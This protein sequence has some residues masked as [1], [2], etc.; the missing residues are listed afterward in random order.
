[1]SNHVGKGDNLP[2]TSL[3]G[4]VDGDKI[5]KGMKLVPTLVHGDITKVHS[6][7]GG[8]AGSGSY[9]HT[10]IAYSGDAVWDNLI[11]VDINKIPI[12]KKKTVHKKSS[13]VAGYRE[14]STTQIEYIYSGTSQKVESTLNVLNIILD[15]NSMGMT[16][17][18][19]TVTVHQDKSTYKKPELQDYIYPKNAN[20]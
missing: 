14:I 2:S 10:I 12:V 20:K 9:S 13:V 8:T 1:M 4:D 19:N 17:E 7:L 5:D 18:M 11:Q 3:A 15:M 16:K 6:T